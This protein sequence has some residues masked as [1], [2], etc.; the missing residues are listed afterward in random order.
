M[1]KPTVASKVSRAK[2]SNSVMKHPPFAS[3]RQ[4]H[5]KNIRL[6]DAQAGKGS[7]AYRM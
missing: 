4:G 5:D 2:I 1:P 6:P 7:T 3:E